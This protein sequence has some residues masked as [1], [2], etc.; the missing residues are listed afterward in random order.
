[1]KLGVLGVDDD[2]LFVFM[3]LFGVDGNG[4]ICMFFIMSRP[5]ARMKGPFALIE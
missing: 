4:G 2:A 5:F 1:M 3:T